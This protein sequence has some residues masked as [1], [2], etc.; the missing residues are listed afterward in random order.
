MGYR[1]VIAHLEGDATLDATI[2][3]VQTRTRQFAKRQETWFRGLAEV[4]RCALGA[5]DGVGMT[6]ERVLGM[7]AGPGEGA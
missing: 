6:V 3:A 1:E 2:A 7:L 5:E 4:R